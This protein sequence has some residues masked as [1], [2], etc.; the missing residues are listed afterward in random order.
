MLSE[1]EQDKIERESDPEDKNRNDGQLDIKDISINYHKMSD[2]I[3]E[4]VSIREPTDITE[5]TRESK[6]K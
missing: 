1:E 5:E 4:S 2:F 3:S 6:E